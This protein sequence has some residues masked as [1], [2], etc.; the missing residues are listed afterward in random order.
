MAQIFNVGKDKLKLSI[1]LHFLYSS[2]MIFLE[3]L[4][5][6]NYLTKSALLLY[7]Q[8]STQF[9]SDSLILQMGEYYVVTE[10]T[11]LFY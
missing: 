8:H 7:E 10:P 11:G 3:E 4:C 2:L 6:T 5:E 1:F 9:S